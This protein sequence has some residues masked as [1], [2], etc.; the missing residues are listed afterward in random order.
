MKGKSLLHETSGMMIFVGSDLHKDSS[1]GQKK[2]TIS[3]YSAF[4]RHSRLIAF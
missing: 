1:G 4:S 2:Q 3:L